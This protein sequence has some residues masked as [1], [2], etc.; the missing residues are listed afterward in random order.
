MPRLTDKDWSKLY[1]E[2]SKANAVLKDFCEDR[3]LSYTYVSRRFAEIAREYEEARI[4]KA[5]R[6]LAKGAPD[7]AQTIVD[8]SIDDDKAI[9]LKA[10]A[11][12]LNRVG[13]SGQAA[14]ITISNSNQASVVLVPLF[15]SSHK[16]SAATVL[17]MEN[18]NYPTRIEDGE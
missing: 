3:A 6:L 7:A 2:F 16:D 8:L 11:D 14:M 15:E 10:S 13:L 17:D 1:D 4:A 12:L 5:R 9:K 18:D